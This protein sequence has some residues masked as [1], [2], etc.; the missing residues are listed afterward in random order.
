MSNTT[1]TTS[2]INN[3]IELLTDPRLSY[4]LGL[5]TISFLD[6]DWQVIEELTLREFTN[7]F[8]DYCKHYSAE[9]IHS[10]HFDDD[11]IKIVFFLQLDYENFSPLKIT[12]N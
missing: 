6:F 2:Y 4:I 7:R 5:T 9:P 12:N 3:F 10:I 1:I 11:T 8:D